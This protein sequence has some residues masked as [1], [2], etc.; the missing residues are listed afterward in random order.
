[1]LGKNW[2]AFTTENADP[3]LL[4]AVSDLRWSHAWYLVTDYVLNASC[5]SFFKCEYADSLTEFIPGTTRECCMSS[6]AY[7]WCTWDWAARLRQTSPL[8]RWAYLGP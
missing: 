2:P 1:M 4:L 7:A 5:W 6:K 8:H 3:L